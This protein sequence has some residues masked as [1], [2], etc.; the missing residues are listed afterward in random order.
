MQ[1]AA[2]AHSEYVP[3]LGMRARPFHSR[4][5]KTAALFRPE[6][7]RAATPFEC[8]ARHHAT[9]YASPDESVTADSASSTLGE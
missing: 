5:H 6:P 9:S 7:L 1:D 8:A 2:V 4:E 3:Q